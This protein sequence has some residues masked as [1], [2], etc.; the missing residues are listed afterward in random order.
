[1]TDGK[2]YKVIGHAK[3]YKRVGEGETGLNTGGM[4]CV[5]P[6]PFMDDKFMDKVITRIINPTIEGFATEQ[7]DY[8]GFVFFGLISVNNEPYVIE[9]NCRMG[10]PETEVVLPRLRNDI[11]ELFDSLYCGTLRNQ[12]IEYNKGSFATVMAVSGGYPG[13]YEKGKPI[14]F[15][16]VSSDVKVFHA[17]TSNSGNEILTNGGR[18]LAVTSC[19]DSIAK[20]VDKSLSA[21]D[22]IRF[23]G[24]HYRRDIGFEFP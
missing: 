2:D 11:V 1:M 19:A 6:V 9:Y 3:D 20:A 16:I 13:D 12:Q 23:A 15:G 22:E 10:D 24:I 7:M 14:A 8:K 4:G 5:S 21:L 17:G 18:V